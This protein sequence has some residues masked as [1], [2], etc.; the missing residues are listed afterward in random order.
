M[1]AKLDPVHTLGLTYGNVGVISVAF[2]GDSLDPVT[3]YQTVGDY[4]VSLP[5]LEQAVLL[6]QSTQ[7]VISADAPNNYNYNSNSSNQGQR[8]FL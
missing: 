1:G 8:H 5:E 6:V 3:C 7:R 4:L 2:P